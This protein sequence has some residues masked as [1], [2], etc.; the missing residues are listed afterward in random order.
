[1]ASG[2]GDVTRGK[3]IGVIDVHL[4]EPH[5]HSADEIGAVTLIGEQAGSALGKMLL[6][7]G[8]FRLAE[9]Q[10]WSRKW[11]NGPPSCRRPTKPS[12]RSCGALS[13]TI[14]AGRRF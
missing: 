6:E 1:M 10:D 7:D 3:S 9:R 8:N 14:S 5:E 4:R 12:A 13:G 2:L 11:P